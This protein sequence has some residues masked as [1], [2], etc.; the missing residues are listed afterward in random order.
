MEGCDFL[1]AF[2]KGLINRS[3]YL[4]GAVGGLL[5]H[6]RAWDWHGDIFQKHTMQV[7]DATIVLCVLES[8][9][10]K[11]VLNRGDR[12]AGRVSLRVDVT[13]R[14]D[15]SRYRVDVDTFNLRLE[16]WNADSDTVSEAERQTVKALLFSLLEQGLA[17][18]ID[19]EIERNR[20]FYLQCEIDRLQRLKSRD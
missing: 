2:D 3:G 4:Y 15:V 5:L 19:E 18:Y 13:E 11:F 14:G 16:Y 20:Q 9:R 1:E 10:D 8:S 7:A 12:D 17:R 6:K